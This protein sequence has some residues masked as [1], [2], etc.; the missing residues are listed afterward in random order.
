MAVPLMVV[1]LRLQQLESLAGVA[2]LLRAGD[3]VPHALHFHRDGNRGRV[4]RADRLAL[5]E[6]PL[7][8]QESGQHLS[9]SLV[10]LA[11]FRRTS[12]IQS[13]HADAGW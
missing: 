6:Q 5:L 10:A 3:R 7:A 9:F 2:A 8:G 1:R 11:A 4:V 12:E 13:E